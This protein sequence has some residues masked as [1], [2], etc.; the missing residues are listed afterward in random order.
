M[1]NTVVLIVKIVAMF[2]VILLGWVTRRRG[3]LDAKT[4]AVL[5]KFTTDVALPAMVF[6]KMLEVVDRQ[7]LRESWVVLVMAAGVLLLGQIIGWLA[8][9]G[10]ANEKQAPTF[11]FVVAIANWIYLPYPIVQELYGA[12]GIRVLLLS[13]VGV[14]FVLWTLG[15]ATLE[16]RFDGRAMLNLFRNPGLIATVGGFFVALYAPWTLAGAEDGALRLSGRA[17]MEAMVMVGSLTIPLSLV[18]TGA[19]LGGLAGAGAVPGRSIAG[20]ALLR[21]VVTPLV[22]IAIAWGLL[23]VGV[24]RLVLAIAVLVA[25]MPVAVSCSI[26]AERFR[27]D[28]A[29][30]AQSIFYT[31]LLS[32]V[33]VPAMFW[34]FTKVG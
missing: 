4:T 25:G 5:S 28:T 30:A 22:A 31:T 16:G 20:V 18:A 33:S 24:P 6:T 17:V 19:Q 32:V 10:F 29:L 1:H 15:V 3:F 13:N 14:Q 12:A 21:L 34:L 11:I 27:Q 2:L 26:L 23:H 9:R 7:S 8:W